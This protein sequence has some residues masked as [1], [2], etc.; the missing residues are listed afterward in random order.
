M[1]IWAIMYPMIDSEEEMN[2]IEKLTEEV[3]E[4]LREKEIPF[5]DIRTSIMIETPAAVMSAGS[6]QEEWIF[7]VSEPTI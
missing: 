4:G 5:H 2:E 6:W 3:K 1:V 7:S